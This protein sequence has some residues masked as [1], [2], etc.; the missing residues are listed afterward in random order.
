MW[1]ISPPV[2]KCLKKVI[3]PID[4][5]AEVCYHICGAIIVLFGQMRQIG[6][7]QTSN[8]K[9]NPKKG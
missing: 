2:K 8:K 3:L 5:R 9:Y 7:D 4:K 6:T 1:H